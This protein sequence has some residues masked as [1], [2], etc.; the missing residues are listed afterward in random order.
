MPEV[1]ALR[2]NGPRSSLLEM[3]EERRSWSSLSAE[4]SPFAGTTFRR[5]GLDESIVVDTRPWLEEEM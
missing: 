3:A 2:M 4:S 1:K 5:G